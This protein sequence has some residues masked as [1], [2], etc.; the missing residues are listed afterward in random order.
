[1]Y[2]VIF[3]IS[4][5]FFFSQPHTLIFQTVWYF[6]LSRY[7]PHAEVP[8]D[9]DTPE[10]RVI[11]IKAVA[12]FMVSCLWVAARLWLNVHISTVDLAEH[13]E[14]GTKSALV[15]RDTYLECYQWSLHII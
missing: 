14:G 5:Y 4:A 13:L 2:V 11:F 10:D 1:M 6:I 15:V 12:Q 9:T 7:D 8:S 3:F